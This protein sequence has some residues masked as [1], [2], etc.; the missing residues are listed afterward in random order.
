MSWPRS[1]SPFIPVAKSMWFGKQ[2]TPVTPEASQAVW[3]W[4]NPAADGALSLYEKAAADGIGSGASPSLIAE[5]LAIS[6]ITAIDFIF[7]TNINLLLRSLY[8]II[9]INDAVEII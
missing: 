9:K 4:T 5:A 6:A 7:W 3:V 8:Y 1:S 2:L